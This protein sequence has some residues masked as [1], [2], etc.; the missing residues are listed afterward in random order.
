MVGIDFIIHGFFNAECQ[1]TG[2]ICGDIIDAHRKGIKIASNQYSTKIVKN[3]DIV[4][5]NGYPM[6]NEG[7]KAYHILRESVKKDGDM[8]F[9]LYTPEGCRVHHYNGKFGSDYGG[10]GWSKTKYIKKPWKM[11][12]VICVSPEL[13]KLDECYYGE[14]SL[15]VKSWDEALKLLKDVHGDNAQVA[16]YPTAAMQFS[17]ENA[18]INL[19]S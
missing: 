6:A 13:S 3:A 17:E 4:V 2:L 19:Q 5:G 18:N 1:I 15:W 14:G 10:R 11:S 8:V 12:R 7:Y 9:L 16:I